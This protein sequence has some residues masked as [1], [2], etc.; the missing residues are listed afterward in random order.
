MRPS[1]AVPSPRQ[2]RRRQHSIGQATR[3]AA[4]PTASV[5][6]APHFVV[7]MPVARIVNPITHANWEGKGVQPDVVVPSRAA[8]EVATVVILKRMLAIETGPARR[9]RIAQWLRDE[10]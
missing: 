5:R 1:R 4:Q 7:D 8:L 9:A 6:L 10:Q 3:G 2:D